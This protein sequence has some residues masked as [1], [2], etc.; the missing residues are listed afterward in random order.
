MFRILDEVKD[1]KT[2]GIS[3]HIRPDGDCVGSCMAMALYLRGAMPKTRVDVFLEDV[4]DALRK[5]VAGTETIHRDFETDVDSYD[6]Y[7]CLDCEKER[8][9]DAMPFFANAKKKINID[10]HISNKGSGD[11]NYIV[12]TASSTC[13]LV[14]NV[15][16]P[17]LLTEPVARNLYIGMVTDTGVFKFS[18]T[19]RSTMEIAGRLMEFGFDFPAIVQ[20]VFCER[21]YVQQQI[22]G[23]ALLES[24]LFQDGRCIFSVIDRKTREFY[25]ATSSDMDGIASELVNT[26]GVYCSIFLYETKPLTY[27]VSLR[28][29]GQV[30]VAAIAGSFGGGGH[31]RAAGCTVNAGYHD[32]INNISA[33]I[34]AQLSGPA[35][36][37]S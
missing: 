14:Y 18:N 3:G 13:E 8:L 16:D 20:E 30:N 29:N 11:L 28:S 17:E 6:V 5:N 36:H 22:M 10:H 19:G 34:A 15:L 26:T 27:K 35:Q 21:S 7:L 37:V 24:V 4:S 31:A 23:R 12:P 9:G 25:R 32:I 33:Q 1:A 2:I